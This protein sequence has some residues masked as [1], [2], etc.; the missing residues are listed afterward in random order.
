V[1]CF[2]APFQKPEPELWSKFHVHSAILAEMSF[3]TISRIR[4]CGLDWSGS[5]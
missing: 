2:Q 1:D 3:R 4:W 5:G